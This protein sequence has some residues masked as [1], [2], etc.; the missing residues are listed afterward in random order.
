MGDLPDLMRRY[1]EAALPDA[2]APVA[3]VRVTQIGEMILRPGKRPLRFSAVEEFAADRVAFAWRA[4]FPLLGPLAMRVVDSYDGRD[5]LLEVRILGVPLQRKRGPDLAQGEAYRYLAEIPW[6]PQAI[7]N[8]SQLEWRALDEHGVEVATRVAG[9][10]VALRLMF[11][12]AGEITQTVAARPR[13]EAGGAVTRWIGEYRDYSSFGGM[14]MPG[15]GEVRWEL[16]EGP[17]TYWRG[18]ITAAETPP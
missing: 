16:P 14:R 12:S 13:L 1:V 8:N 10:R 11:N 2:A 4:R 9:E 5:G 15:R 7:L 3:T 17:F 6:V 18:T